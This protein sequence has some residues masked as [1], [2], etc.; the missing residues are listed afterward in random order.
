[1]VDRNARR[2]PSFGES[3][4]YFGSNIPGKPRKYLLWEDPREVR[5]E[6]PGLDDLNLIPSGPTSLAST[7]EKPS[8][9]HLVFAMW[10]SNGPPSINSFSL[11]NV[12]G[13]ALVIAHH[14]HAVRRLRN[15]HAVRVSG[16]ATFP[17]RRNRLLRRLS[18]S[19]QQSGIQTLG[20]KFMRRFEN[21]LLRCPSMTLS[22]RRP[23]SPNCWRLAP[24]R[25]RA[26]CRDWLHRRRRA[27]RQF[28]APPSHVE[29][30]PLPSSAQSIA[31]GG[32]SIRGNA[33]VWS[34]NAKN[35][36]SRRRRP[37]DQ[38]AAVRVW[39]EYALIGSLAPVQYRFPFQ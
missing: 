36:C 15:L 33:R 11:A 6:A 27:G 28:E 2:A 7:S 32:F 1:M 10:T 24:L 38:A 31:F 20:R 17:Q 18:A 23:E 12:A 26:G 30:S 19:R 13:R 25:Y 16:P 9:P 39:K 14:L 8:T 37:R 4:Y 21:I 29:S 22:P 5:A 35:R 3:S 34:R